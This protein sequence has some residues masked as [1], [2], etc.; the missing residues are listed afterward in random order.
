MTELF[1][2]PLTPDLRQQINDSIRNSVRE[3]NT[4]QNN[5]YVNM[6]KTAL[7][8]TKALID[9]LPDGYPMPMY[10]R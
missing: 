7:N 1:Y 10:R 2:K 3:L 9:A 5:V 8:A 6:Q 4:C